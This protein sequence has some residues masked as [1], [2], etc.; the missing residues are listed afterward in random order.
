MLGVV[1]LCVG[2]V[3][4]INGL[5]LIGRARAAAAGMGA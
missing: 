4:V 3:L 5:W 1:L 2:A